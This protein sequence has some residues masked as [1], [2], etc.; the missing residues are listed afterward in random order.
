MIAV[1]LMQSKKCDGIEYCGIQCNA[2]QTE[3]LFTRQHNTK[4]SMSE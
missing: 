4:P 3:K 2:V 1:E